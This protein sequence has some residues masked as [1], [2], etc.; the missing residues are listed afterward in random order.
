[1]PV[2]PP[3]DNLFAGVHKPGISSSAALCTK[4]NQPNLR[5]LL[6]FSPGL[7]LDLPPKSVGAFVDKMFAIRY[8]PYK[9]WLSR[10]WSIID[11]ISHIRRLNGWISPIHE[12]FK[13][14][15]TT[16]TK[17]PPNSVGA[18]VDK[19]FAYRCKPRQTRLLEVW[20]INEQ[21]KIKPASL[22]K[23]R[24]FLI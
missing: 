2:D 3:V 6:G 20:S 9:T 13:G 7:G 23:S 1:M 17:L 15:S 22:N 10:G 8:K 24:I 21:L 4:N 16:R 18:S 14:F 12:G 19:V 5:F 11:Q